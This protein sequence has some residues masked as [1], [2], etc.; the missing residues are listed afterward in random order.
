MKNAALFRGI[1]E[2]EVAAFAPRYADRA[3][4][5]TREGEIRVYGCRPREHEDGTKNAVFVMMRSVDNGLSYTLEEVPEDDPGARI[6]SPWSDDYFTMI[7]HLDEVGNSAH[8]RES[9]VPGPVQLKRGIKGTWLYRSKG[10]PDGPWEVTQIS[11]NII[12]IRI[13]PKNQK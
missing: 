2:P 5:I 6:A 3:M 9:H 11:E 7:S 12:Q 1:F 4:M 13:A 10:G 8:C